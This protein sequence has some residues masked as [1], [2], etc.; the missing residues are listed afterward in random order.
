MSHILNIY[1]YIFLWITLVMSHFKQLC[2]ALNAV[3]THSS[4]IIWISLAMSHWMQSSVCNESV[5]S[6]HI[7]NSLDYLVALSCHSSNSPQCWQSCQ[8]TVSSPQCWQSCHVTVQAQRNVGIKLVLHVTFEAHRDAGA[9]VS[10]HIS[11]T[12]SRVD[13]IQVEFKQ[14]CSCW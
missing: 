8:I 6:C 14:S 4:T 3:I 1:F 7:S 9:V 11:Y 12:L 2:L 5:M 10:C 13:F